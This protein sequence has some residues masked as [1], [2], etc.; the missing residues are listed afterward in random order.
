MGR[1]KEI[2]EHFEE[3]YARELW[4]SR[5]LRPEAPP[6]AL[7]RDAAALMRLQGVGSGHRGEIVDLYESTPDR[8]IILRVELADQAAEKQRKFEELPF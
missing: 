5:N 4:V 7:N 1:I 6:N 3:K 2:K 8:R